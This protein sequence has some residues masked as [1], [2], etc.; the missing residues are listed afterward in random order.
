MGGDYWLGKGFVCSAR[1]R[2]PTEASVQM[3]IVRRLRRSRLLFCAVP[4]GGKRSRATAKSLKAQGVTA[5]V[6]DL[7]IFESP[8]SFPDKVGVAL[9]LKRRNGTWCRVSD[10]QRSWLSGLADRN[11]ISVVGYGEEDAL[12]KLRELGFGV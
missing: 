1:I 8:P 5:G 6:P 10:H 3:A 2:V 11:W 7:L 4:N 9:E 12:A